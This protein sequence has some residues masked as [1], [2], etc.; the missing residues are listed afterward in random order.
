MSKGAGSMKLRR[1]QTCM[2]AS[3]SVHRCSPALPSSVADLFNG[4]QHVI[5]RHATVQLASRD[6]VVH[7]LRGARTRSRSTGRLPSFLPPPAALALANHSLAKFGGL[8]MEGSSSS[9]CLSEAYTSMK[10]CMRRRDQVVLHHRV[11]AAPPPPPQGSHILGMLVLLDLGLLG[12]G[13]HGREGRACTST[14]AQEP[15]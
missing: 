3:Q 14:D 13:G 11:C 10:S 4:R 9:S 2:H 8:P 7:H 15:L 5:H 6:I 12:R 1:M